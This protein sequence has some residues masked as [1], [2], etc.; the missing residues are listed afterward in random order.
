MKLRVA[1]C[2][3]TV[4]L[5]PAVV[6]KTKF[7]VSSKTLGENTPYRGRERRRGRERF[8][9]RA[10]QHFALQIFHFC[11]LRLLRRDVCAFF[12]D[13]AF[14]QE[15]EESQRDGYGCKDQEAIKIGQRRGLL[16]A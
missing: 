9:T 15:H 14:H 16:L 3:F 8:A 10:D 11:N 2:A 7:M 1:F 12:G 13:G 4:L 5:A 6:A